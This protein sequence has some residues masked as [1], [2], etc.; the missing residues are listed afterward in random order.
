MRKIGFSLFAFVALV[1]ASCTREP[2]TPDE[3]HISDLGEN[4]L[5]FTIV[6][7]ISTPA[8][9]K[10]GKVAR[11][12]GVIDLGETEDGMPLRFVESVSSAVIPSDSIMTKGSPATTDNVKTLYGCFSAVA[13]AGTT[14]P[15]SIDGETEFVFSY[16]SADLNWAHIFE[17]DPWGTR[18]EM[19][20]FTYMPERPAGTT[21]DPSAHT[22]SFSYTTPEAASDQKDLL[23]GGR[24]TTKTDF[25]SNPLTSFPITFH[26][27]LAGVKFAIGND[28]N[29]TVITKVVMKGIVKTGSFVITPGAATPVSCTPGSTTADYT[30][31][32]PGVSE[33]GGVK[34]L[35]DEALSLTLWLIPQTL[36]DDAELEVTYNVNGGT[37][38]TVSAKINA[39]LGSA[40]TLTAGELHTFT[41]N[42]DDVNV[43][44]TDEISG[45]VKQNV[46]I[47]NTGNVE[48]YLRAVIVANWQDADGN[49]VAAW[50][51]EP[52]EFVG[53]P[54]T[55]WVQKSDGYY[56]TTTTIAAGADAPTLFTSYTPPAAPV[57]GAH[58]VMDIAVQAVNTKPTSWAD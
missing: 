54:G 14:G 23:F 26:H 19:Y 20:F 55:G 13:Y 24:N 39:A 17:S 35:N 47:S 48:A 38:R 4:T 27:A 22:I 3:G 28:A 44:I 16:R 33:A 58:L 5:L 11:E 34:N 8:A 29:S 6:E 36:S 43:S 41:L 2:L 25:T 52:T 32:V 40:L 10:S 31:S 56:Y 46:I 50:D 7:E 15:V 53:L 51:F 9:V 49:I 37:S 57:T 21:F 30:I 12:T 1:L 45:G 42:P 18:T